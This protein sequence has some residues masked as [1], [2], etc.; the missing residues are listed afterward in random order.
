MRKITYRPFVLLIGVLLLTMSL[1]Q[2]LTERMRGAVISSIA[3][4]WQFLAFL[5][6]GFFH[7]IAMVP[8]HHKASSQ[9]TSEEMSRLLQENQ[10]L[11]SQM[12]SVRAWLV[13]EERLEEQVQRMKNISTRDDEDD[14]WKDFYRRRARALCQAL[15]L[16]LQSLPAKVIFREP[17]SWSSSVW[18]N[19][20]NWNNETLRKVVVAKNSPVVVGS[21]IVG[22]IEYVGERQ[23]RMRLISDSGLVPSVRAVRGGEQNRFLLEHLDAVLCGLQDKE[24][25]FTSQEER[26]QLL[27]SLKQ[28]QGQLGA[29]VSEFYLAKGELRGCSTPLWRSRSE[30]LQGVGFNYDY[31]DEEGLARDLR[32][33]EVAGSLKDR[34]ALPI[35][36]VGDLLVTTGMDGVFP[37]GFRIGLVT[38]VGLLRE[39]ACAYELEAQPT[40]GNLDELTDVFVLPP[41]IHELKDRSFS[42]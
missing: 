12:A 35:L 2:N 32:T 20:G 31:A 7:L 9:E 38:K 15:D 23:S 26:N 5:K 42:P 22:V 21:S 1:S 14:S 37:T 13:F 11:R 27:N 28:L 18:L 33:G 6:G 29:Q 19:V 36:K 8:P 41:L 39:G 10:T 17:A 4:S 16:E 34:G 24:D 25:V 30:L 40:A 3:P